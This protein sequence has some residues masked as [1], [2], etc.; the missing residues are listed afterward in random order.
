MSIS[1]TYWANKIKNIIINTIL[2]LSSLLF[3]F[4]ILEGILVILE[5][6]DLAK[7][8]EL[9]EK[10][11]KDIALHNS[12]YAMSN[13]FAVW[14]NS[15]SN[16][17]L[18]TFTDTVHSLRKKTRYRITVLGDSVIWGDGMPYNM[19]WSHR[20]EK[21]L[22][23]HDDNVEVIHWGKSGWSTK[24]ELEFLKQ[25]G[26][27]YEFDLLIISFTLNDLEDVDE[28]VTMRERIK[29]LP[30][31]KWEKDYWILAQIYQWLPRSYRLIRSSIEKMLTRYVLTGYGYENYLLDQVY[32]SKRLAQYGI[33]LRELK[34][35]C[36][37]RNIRLLF[38]LTVYYDYHFH[39]KIFDRLIPILEK[40]NIQYIDLL[41]ALQQ[42]LN[43]EGR[44]E[45]KALPND[46]HPNYL[47]TKMF[48]DEVSNY[49]IN[50]GLLSSPI[51][52][53]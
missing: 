36:R 3:T 38:A 27:Q 6:D 29:H 53:Q 51:I 52:P 24:E 15:F 20:L 28:Y 18:V 9:F 1:I 39:R 4:L 8:P 7:R 11:S 23:K 50:N 19:V 14:E 41:P 17:Y 31:G 30:W 21:I 44:I 32:T 45:L 42:K 33:L 25:F 46:G 10:V 5:Y 47:L 13:P 35:I 37:K 2:F 34:E 40:N 48:A 22:R 26:L 12:Q 43:N 16:K 49:I